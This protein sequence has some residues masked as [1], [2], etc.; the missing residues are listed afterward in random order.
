M[1]SRSTRKPLPPDS[2]WVSLARSVPVPSWKLKSTGA[3][4]QSLE[5][6]SPLGISDSYSGCNDKWSYLD[7]RRITLLQK[8]IVKTTKRAHTR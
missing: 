2:Q 4:L 1:G 3:C 8:M 5:R 7:F 6:T